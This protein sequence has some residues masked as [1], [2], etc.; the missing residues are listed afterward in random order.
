MM[1]KL[2]RPYREA[3][4]RA[5]KIFWEATYQNGLVV[6]EQDGA[7][8]ESLNRE[9]LAWF[10]IVSPGEVI[11]EMK[12]DGTRTGKNLVWRRRRGLSHSTDLWKEWHLVGWAPMG[13]VWAIDTVRQQKIMAPSFLNGHGVFYPPE[14]VQGED[15]AFVET[16]H[17]VDARIKPDTI[18]TPSG[19]KLRN[20]NE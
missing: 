10:R 2:T 4:N 15:I 1:D 19:Y 13:P 20:S 3:Y 12:C 11:H 14:P 16:A 18:V 8:Y 7:S 6:R 17:G 9:Q 5:G